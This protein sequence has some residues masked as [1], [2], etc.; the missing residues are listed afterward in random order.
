MPKCENQNENPHPRQPGLASVFPVV[1]A[2][3][4]LS[5]CKP[6]TRVTRLS[7]ATVGTGSGSLSGGVLLV[8]SLPAVARGSKF[9]LSSGACERNQ[10]KESLHLIHGDAGVG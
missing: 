5:T 9:S 2:E 8:P 1:S 7:G 6:L 3:S 10:H 4:S